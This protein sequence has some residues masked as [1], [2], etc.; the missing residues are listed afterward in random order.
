MSD[1]SLDC[2]TIAKVPILHAN[3]PT[4]PPV[5]ARTLRPFKLSREQYRQGIIK[6]TSRAVVKPG[7]QLGGCYISDKAENRGSVK[8]CDS[9]V[10]RYYGFWK[11]TGHRASWNNYFTSECDGCGE[12]HCLVILFLPEDQ[13]S[14]VL[15]GM[16]GKFASPK[17][18]IFSKLFKRSS[19]SGNQKQRSEL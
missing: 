3:V 18:T 16:H 9:C 5:D 19:L 12:S 17:Q 8:L 10:T 14:S 2:K 15:G 4:R 1:L 6:A 11:Q 7:M 13:F